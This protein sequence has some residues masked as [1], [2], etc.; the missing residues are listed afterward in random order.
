VLKNQQKSRGVIFLYSSS[1]SS[2]AGPAMQKLIQYSKK[3]K[4]DKVK[5]VRLNT[6][7]E[8]CGT[9]SWSHRLGVRICSIYFW[10]K[11]VFFLYFVPTFL[12]MRRISTCSCKR[13]WWATCAC[14]YSHT[15]THK[16]MLNIKVENYGTN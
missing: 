4:W 1:T 14:E 15:H 12:T 5:K 16:H 8:S 9:D 13:V 6:A 11:I 3:S 2:L 10:C 7:F